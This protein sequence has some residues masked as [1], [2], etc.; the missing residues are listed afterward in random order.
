MISN[1]NENLVGSVSFRAEMNTPALG[2]DLDMLARNIQRMGDLAKSHGVTL[3]P[4]AKAHKSPR[5]AKMQIDAGA[6][7]V[8]CTTLGEAEVMAAGG[9]EDILITAPLPAAKLDRLGR[10]LACVPRLS[11]VVDQIDTVERL[12]TLAEG[13]GNRVLT[14]LVDVDVGQRRTGVTTP[15]LAVGLARRIDSCPGLRFGGIQGYA[16]TL[17]AI[18]SFEERA[19]KCREVHEKLR[20]VRS[21]LESSGFRCATVTGAGTGTVMVDAASGVFTELQPG[22]YLYMDAQYSGVQIGTDDPGPFQTGLRFF[23]RIISAPHPGVATT[24]GGHKSMPADGPAAP[25]IVAGAP[26]GTAYKYAGDEFGRLE[27]T[28]PTWRAQVGTLI[29]CHVPHCDTAMAVHDFLLGF[30][31]DRLETL[32]RIEGRGAW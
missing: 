24:D 30:R 28:D 11:M 6:V 8:C 4:H 19:A 25:K 2:V 23:T 18:V 13:A 29:E 14:V 27:F 7:G 10:L 1:A 26:E 31:G 15:E 32:F 12:R 21:Q 22:S 20:V 5:I 17:Q 16:G 9:V 3:R